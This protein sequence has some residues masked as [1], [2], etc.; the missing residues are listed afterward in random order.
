MTTNDKQF[1]KR[2][3]AEEGVT[4]HDLQ[5]L[6]PPQTILG[7]SPAQGCL[8]YCEKYKTQFYILQKLFD[9]INAYVDHVCF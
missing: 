9:S 5:I 7:T 4:P 2:F 1:Y 8:R 3:N 6:S